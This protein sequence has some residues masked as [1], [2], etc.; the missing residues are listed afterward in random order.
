MRA[1]MAGEQ[2]EEVPAMAANNAQLDMTLP[3]LRLPAS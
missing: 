2:R 1:S 3:S